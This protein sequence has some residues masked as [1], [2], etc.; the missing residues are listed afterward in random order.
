MLLIDRNRIERIRIILDFQI[1]NLLGNNTPNSEGNKS[2]KSDFFIDL[3]D[4]NANDTM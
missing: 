4:W 1:L 2:M 3:V